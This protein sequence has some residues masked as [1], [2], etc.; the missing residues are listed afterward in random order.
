MHSTRRR[1]L[2]GAVGLAALAGCLADGPDPRRDGGGD[3]ADGNGDDGSEDDADGSGDDGSG[4]ETDGSGDDGSGDETDENG[5]EEDGDES[6]SEE[7]GDGEYALV[8]HGTAAYALGS[9][10]PAVKT[11]HERERLEA[12][13]GGDDPGE[14]VD[15]F[16]ADIEF[17]RSMVVAIRIEVRNPCHAFE[18]VDVAVEDD[19]LAV[20]TTLL[21]ETDDEMACAQVIQYPTLLVRA[22]FEDAVPGEARVRL[23]GEVIDEDVLYPEGATAGPESDPAA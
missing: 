22:T 18:L 1:L 14:D 4:D 2:A 13:L 3:D 5:S 12:W 7:D 19:R 10:E 9:A 16:V 23:D 21:D 11:F 20:E 17:D 8:D 15:R 6:G